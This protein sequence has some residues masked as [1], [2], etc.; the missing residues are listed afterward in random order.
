[1]ATTFTP[2]TLRP[3][4]RPFMADPNTRTALRIDCPECKA[5]RDIPCYMRRV[6]NRIEQIGF[7]AARVK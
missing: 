6:G 2:F 4:L 3:Q 1:M 7:C 5:P